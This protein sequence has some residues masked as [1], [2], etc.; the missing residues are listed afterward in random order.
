MEK[1]YHP[2]KMDDPVDC[3]LIYFLEFL[4]RCYMSL[5]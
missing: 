3:L 2:A 1:E 5:T 4:T